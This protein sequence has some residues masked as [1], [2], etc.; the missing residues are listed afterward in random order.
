MAAADGEAGL[1]SSLHLLICFHFRVRN[2]EKPKQSIRPWTRSGFSILHLILVSFRFC[3]NSLALARQRRSVG[4]VCHCRLWC[5]AA[6]K[7]NGDGAMAN[8]RSG[9]TL[10]SCDLTYGQ[11]DTMAILPNT[12]LHLVYFLVFCIGIV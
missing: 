10:V 5:H 4:Q 3:R 6:F 11:G 9:P 8:P 12:C 2:E 1:S 7:S